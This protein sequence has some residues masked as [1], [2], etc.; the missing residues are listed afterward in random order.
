MNRQVFKD[1][2]NAAGMVA[3][4]L[5]FLSFVVFQGF[6]VG[7]NFWLNT[8][9]GDAQLENYSTTDFEALQEGNNYYLTI[10]GLL[11]VF[12]C[13]LFSICTFFLV[14]LKVLFSDP[15]LVIFKWNQSKIL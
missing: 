14:Y 12:Q 11:G 2:G 9:T 15:F 6:S 7:A 10:Y 13:K 5:A 3:L 8:W 1:Y 4:V